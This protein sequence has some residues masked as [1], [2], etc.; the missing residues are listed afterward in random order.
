MNYDNDENN[1]IIEP[2]QTEIRTVKGTGK[3]II[4]KEKTI[5]DMSLEYLISFIAKGITNKEDF[6]TKIKH[7]MLL[8]QA[9]IEF[10]KIIGQ[11]LMKQQIA[12][13]VV[14]LLIPRI[15]GDP[16]EKEMM[17]SL[18]YGPPGTGK[19]ECATKIAKIFYAIGFGNVEKNKNKRAFENSTLKDEFNDL[20]NPSQGTALIAALMAIPILIA[21]FTT[22]MSLHS[23]LGF[24]KFITL[25][26]LIAFAAF[27]I[28]FWVSG[29]SSEESFG[30]SFESSIDSENSERNI[31]NISNSDIIKI[32]SR[33]DFVGK[34]VGWSEEATKKILDSALGKVLFIDEAYSLNNGGDGFGKAVLDIINRYMTEH[35]GEIVIIFAGYEDQIEKYLLNAQE[36]L[37]RRF[38]QKFNCNGYTADELFEIFMYHLE[39][40][41]KYKIEINKDL[42][43]KLED[44]NKVKELFH[45]NE[46]YFPNYGGDVVSLLA[47]AKRDHDTV[48][49]KNLDFKTKTLTLENMKV[50]FTEL[51]NNSKTKNHTSGEKLSDISKYE[52]LFKKLVKEA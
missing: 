52:D 41:G 29:Y 34:Y 36:G 33:E 23:S 19:T 50:A 35:A 3:K 46:S 18:I 22:L 2:T 21:V 39:E 32:T 11:K 25:M 13:C 48:M 1:E 12:K 45:Q 44:E 14:R 4:V 26:C 17:H 47:F 16:Y 24:W 40:R 51:R 5:E 20:L 42:R 10:D 15:R 7:P 31:T 8:L 38:T 6:I 28:Y 30:N 43:W 37:Y 49:F 27:F 9:L